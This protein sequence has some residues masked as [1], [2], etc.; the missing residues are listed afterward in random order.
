MMAAIISLVVAF[1]VAVKVKAVMR[2]GAFLLTVLIMLPIMAY[3][4]SGLKLV[5]A[6][7]TGTTIM[8][9]FFSIAGQCYTEP[10]RLLST[11]VEG[12]PP[13]N[14]SLA[15]T[16]TLVLLSSLVV[17]GQFIVYLIHQHQGSQPNNVQTSH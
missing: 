6:G 5:L 14:F 16:G 17:V 13:L 7:M 4:I 2:F 3:V 15:L 10:F 12:A 9:D 8:G 11:P 1:L